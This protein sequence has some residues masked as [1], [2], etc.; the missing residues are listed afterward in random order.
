MMENSLWRRYNPERDLAGVLARVLLCESISLLPDERELYA[1]LKR[2]LT[3]K[4]LRLF[5]MS[6]A[7]LSEAAICEELSLEA[8]S[9]EK[10]KYRVY[11]KIVQPKIS[12]GVRN[13]A[14]ESMED[15]E[16]AE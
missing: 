2:H 3:K 10:M 12:E 6:E 14:G 16:T 7:A 4:E 11:R 9:Y 13:R 8:E 5:I 1:V 15:E